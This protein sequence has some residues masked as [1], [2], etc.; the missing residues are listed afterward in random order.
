MGKLYYVSETTTPI[1]DKHWM[2][3]WT[4]YVSRYDNG[5]SERRKIRKVKESMPFNIR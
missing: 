3:G 2:L 1:N 5:S 4:S